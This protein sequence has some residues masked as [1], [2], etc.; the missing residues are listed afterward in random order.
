MMV[1]D[2]DSYG[3]NGDNCF[4]P[5]SNY[6]D[7]IAQKRMDKLAK[8]DIRCKLDGDNGGCR[9]FLGYTPIIE[10]LLEKEC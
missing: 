9:E 7:K 5:P 2:E 4:W 10:A 8:S 1:F 6:S 3:R